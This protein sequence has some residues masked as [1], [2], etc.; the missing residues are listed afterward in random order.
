MWSLCHV[1]KGLMTWSTGCYC[2]EEELRAGVKV[3]CPQKGFRFPELL[4]KINNIVGELL[5]MSREVEEDRYRGF[6]GDAVSCLRYTAGL[7]RA[8]CDY[9]DKLPYSLARCRLRDVTQQCLDEFDGLSEADKTSAH[10]VTIEFCVGLR[11]DME[12][13]AS[14]GEL[15]DRLAQADLRCKPGR[16]RNSRPDGSGQSRFVISTSPMQSKK[17]LGFF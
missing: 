1:L 17:F 10:R 5:Q 2:H 4:P 9:L 11:S 12:Q 7:L 6:F 8:R 16:V 15:T 3:D 14:G 13:W